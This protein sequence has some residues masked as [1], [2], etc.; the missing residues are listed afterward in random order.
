MRAEEPFLIRHADLIFALKTF[1]ASIL[2]LVVALAMDLPRPYWAMA[3]VYI[4]S[5]PLAGAT[6][7]K[8]FFRVVGTVVGATVTVAMV[9]NLIDAPELLGICTEHPL[10]VNLANSIDNG[11]RHHDSGAGSQV[12]GREHSSKHYQHHRARLCSRPDGALG[13]A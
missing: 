9:P 12:R 6:S 3:T 11:R 8:A 4:T 5:Q 13:L 10:G 1:T 7:S 2:A